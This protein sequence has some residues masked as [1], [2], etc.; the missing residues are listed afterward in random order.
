MSLIRFFLKVITELDLSLI[1]FRLKVF[2]ARWSDMSGI[3]WSRP[4]VKPACT[5]PKYNWFP[6]RMTEGRSR[7]GN[8]MSTDE[9][10]KKHRS[11]SQVPSLHGVAEACCF[12]LPGKI[13]ELIAA[14]C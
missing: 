10:T 14:P 12:H 6:D 8:G 2:L 3:P 4:E 1:R 11:D 5:K 7:F 9:Y 13:E